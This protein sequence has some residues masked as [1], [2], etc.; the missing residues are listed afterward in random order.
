MG[1][2]GDLAANAAEQDGWR[3]LKATAVAVLDEWDAMQ[4]TM[5][6]KQKM[7]DLR[8]AVLALAPPVP[9]SA[10]VWDIDPKK[11][12]ARVGGKVM[13]T[14]TEQADGTWVMETDGRT[15]PAFRSA[16]AARRAF[17]NHRLA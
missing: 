17:D 7:E 8:A 12:F 6:L 5:F 11:H 15:W 13:A 3:R 16:E 14:V 10:T 9:M 2:G 1:I 4:F